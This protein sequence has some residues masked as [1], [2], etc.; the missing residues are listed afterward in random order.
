MRQAHT[1]PRSYLQP[2]CLFAIFWLNR[3][4]CSHPYSSTAYYI[5]SCPVLSCPVCN[6]T[7][8]GSFRTV[9]PFPFSLPSLPSFLVS[10]CDVPLRGATIQA[11][12]IS[13]VSSYSTP[14]ATAAIGKLRRP[15][16]E[17]QQQQQQHLSLSPHARR[18]LILFF[19][20]SHT[21]RDDVSR[22]ATSSPRQP[23]WLRLC[24]RPRP[25]PRPH[26]HECQHPR[27]AGKY[28]PPPAGP[29]CV[30]CC[31]FLANE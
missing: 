8:K 22:A 3:R 2:A 30:G 12:S 24:H 25:R 21:P 27:H 9:L 31:P 6:Q 7:P 16:R 20:S 19:S 15:Q 29:G 4:L 10:L 1:S 17:Q 18:A 14:S 5:V 28:L 26:G 23:L 11:K 13:R